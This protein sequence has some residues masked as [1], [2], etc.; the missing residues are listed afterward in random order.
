MQ[1]SFSKYSWPSISES[2]A[3]TNHGIKTVFS[4]H[5][6]ES[7]DAEGGVDALFY[8]ILC[9]EVEPLRMLLSEGS[10]EPNPLGYGGSTMFFL[11]H[12]GLVHI[13]HSYD[14]EVFLLLS[15]ILYLTQYSLSLR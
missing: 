7:V 3:S 4:I 9:K 14:R 6:W 2:L 1:I 5:D 8:V 15:L 12:S 11:V 10:L 13:R